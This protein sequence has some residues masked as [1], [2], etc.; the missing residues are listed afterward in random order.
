MLLMAEFYSTRK[1]SQE[2]RNGEFKARAQQRI[3]ITQARAAPASWGHMESV[4]GVQFTAMLPILVTGLANEDQET[5]K[6]S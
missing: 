6:K 5:H 4:S 1:I 2:G 3:S